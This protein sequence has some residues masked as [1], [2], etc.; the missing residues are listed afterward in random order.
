MNAILLVRFNECDFTNV[1]EWIFGFLNLRTQL[2]SNLP[3][4]ADIAQWIHLCIPSATRGSSP[5][6][7]IYA[8]IIY[9]QIC[10][11]KERK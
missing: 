5:K 11:W 1:I 7:T 2:N 9:S 3:R 10:Q 8:F 6:H 4:G